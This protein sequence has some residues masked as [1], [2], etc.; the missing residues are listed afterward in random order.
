M[1]ELTD[2]GRLLRVLEYRDVDRGVYGVH[3]GPWP[4]TVERWRKEGLPE[5]VD[6]GTLFATRFPERD[7]WHWEGHW[8]FP[9]PPFEHRAIS[10]DYV[11]HPDHSLPPD[12]P[13]ENF[14]YFMERLRE[15]VAI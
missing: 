2:R 5:D 1:H 11:A 15:V 14:L 10:E 8:F 9:F 13:F 4:E 3:V 6:I 12:V 7:R